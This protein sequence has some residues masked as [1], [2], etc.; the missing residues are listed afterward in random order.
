MERFEHGGVPVFWERGE[1]DAMAALLF[2]AGIADEDP[3][4]RGTTHL[5]EH[6][7]LFAL[8]RR[9]YTFNGFVDPLYTVFHARGSQDEVAAFLGDV[10]RSLADLPLERFET[11]V[12]V[13][14]AEAGQDPGDFVSRM[15]ML[16]FGIVSFGATF[17]RELGL[18]TLGPTDVERR[19]DEAFTA[20]NA[21]IWV[22]SPEPLELDLALAD[23]ARRPPPP[24]ETLSGLEF[25]AWIASGTGGVAVSMLAG[26]SVA[27]SLALGVA[28][29]RL[30]QRLRVDE[31]LAYSVDGGRLPLGPDLAHVSV[32]A[33]CLDRNGQA[34]A[35]RVLEVLA[36]LAAEGPTEEEFE[37]LHR[38]AERVPLDDPDAIRSALDFAATEELIGG[39]PLDAEELRRQRL[40]ATPEEARAAL[41]SAFASRIVIVP[42]A[43]PRPADD[44]KE[45]ERPVTRFEGRVHEDR[46]AP[47]GDLLIVDDAGVYW[48][49]GKQAE[50]SIPAAEV[51]FVARRPGGVLCV[52]GVDSSWIEID[53]RRIGD[54]AEAAE[55]V[56]RLAGGAERFVPEEPEGAAAVEELAE[57]SLDRVWEVGSELDVLPGALH[58]GEVPRAM[59][60]GARGMKS[61]LLVLTD[62]RL[63]FL[64]KKPTGEDFVEL[65]LSG[66][67]SAEARSSLLGGTKLRVAYE[68]DR[69]EFKG[70]EPKERAGEIAEGI[71]EAD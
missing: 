9:D 60:R 6:L 1:G 46:E 28:S 3:S 7:A 27:M 25:P 30:H 13:L 71:A 32:G 61:G 64:S 26:R 24:S 23:G 4:R 55:T 21:A 36:S 29:E 42:D 15:L 2:R 63:I 38:R 40:A 5:V 22:H 52:Y 47:K 34:V 67:E 51:A 58:P 41:E 18:K 43:C 54:G 68:G 14:R 45:L 16:R 65:P 12:E 20:G 17:L 31:G 57:Q 10:T 59:A 33:D 37:D 53:P 50:V 19:R 39:E 8:G 48:F 49:D 66:L 56:A 11:E 44:L 70:I 35:A 62:R 69:I